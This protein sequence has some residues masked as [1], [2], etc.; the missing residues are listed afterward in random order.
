MKTFYKNTFST[1]QDFPE[2]QKLLT[3]V[4]RDVKTCK[5][6]LCK[7]FGCFV[8]KVS[9]I[10]ILRFLVAFFGTFWNFMFLFGILFHYLCLLS[11]LFGLKLGLS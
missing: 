2:E 3:A 11:M 6:C 4:G 5:Q 9:N 1:F 10:A 8:E 7:I